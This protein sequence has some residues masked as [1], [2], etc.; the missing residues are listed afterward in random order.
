M[1]KKELIQMSSR[2]EAHLYVAVAKADGNLSTKERVRTPYYAQQSQ[3]SYTFSKS[4]QAFV[5]AIKVETQ[6]VLSDSAFD[7]WT[8]Q[9]HLDEGI[10]ILKEAERQGF[11]GLDITWAKLE[12][13][14]ENVAYLDGFDMR[15]SRFVKKIIESLKDLK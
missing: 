14:L 12:K 7:H 13:D 4:Q 3:K 6:S 15:E 9:M 8:A 2:G 11:S 5:D 1:N 10:R